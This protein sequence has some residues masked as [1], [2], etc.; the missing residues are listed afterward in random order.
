MDS[1][2]IEIIIRILLAC[3]LGGII[4]LERESVNRPAGFRTHILV[5][6]G[7]T[8]VMITNIELV[9]V[10][11]GIA[12]VQPG[13]FGAAVVSGI[14]FLGAGT[15]IKEG[16]SVKGL[17]TAAS[18]WAT[19]CIGLALGT[20]L[21]VIAFISTFFVYLTLEVFP[22]IE[23]RLAK[24]RTMSSILITS[25]NKIGQLSIIGKA[26]EDLMI[27]INGIKTTTTKHFNNDLI[28]IELIIKCPVTLTK[29]EL[30][31]NILSINGIVEV[32][33]NSHL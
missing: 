13:R 25:E 1:N 5:T 15:I 10:M 21:Y 18:L 17:T 19:A 16:N 9:N 6:L 23:H 3:V 26:L 31:S 12:T 8:I 22:K 24:T 2:T 4:G 20:G 32:I 11:S 7:A 29:T 14:G 30:I 28:K 27:N 33:V